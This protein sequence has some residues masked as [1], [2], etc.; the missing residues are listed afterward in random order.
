MTGHAVC[1][2]V[3]PAI[4]SETKDKDIMFNMLEVTHGIHLTFDFF[5]SYRQKEQ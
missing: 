5:T 4:F 2:V 3:S 1:S